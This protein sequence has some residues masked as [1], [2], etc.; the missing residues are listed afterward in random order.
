[1]FHIPTI[2]A[3]RAAATMAPL[4]A[5]RFAVHCFA[6]NAGVNSALD[7]WALAAERERLWK[8]R[9]ARRNPPFTVARRACAI[10]S[11]NCRGISCSAPRLLVASAV[12]GFGFSI[13][14]FS[15]ARVA[16]YSDV[17]CL[18]KMQLG[19]THL[20]LATAAARWRLSE[21]R[22]APSS[23]GAPPRLSRPGA[24]HVSGFAAPLF[25]E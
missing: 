9:C 20:H 6:A 12:D 1:M 7:R 4:S 24:A 23:Y 3:E 10:T 16:V 2:G 21:R 14:G 15:C 17:A 13:F 11:R 5:A 25:R 8:S 22:R 19:R 18:M